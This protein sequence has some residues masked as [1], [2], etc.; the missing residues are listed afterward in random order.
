MIPIPIAEPAIEIVAEPAPTY[1]KAV[2]KLESKDKETLIISFNK[3][4]IKRN[5]K[6][7]II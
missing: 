6:K 7:L 4:N 1:L 2:K 5:P 3:F